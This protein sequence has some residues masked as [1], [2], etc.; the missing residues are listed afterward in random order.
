[1]WNSGSWDEP[2]GDAQV[3]PYDKT[4]K[5]D[6]SGFISTNNYGDN[7]AANKNAINN[8]VIICMTAF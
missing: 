4:N 7:N 5:N 2:A 1:M 8:I 3:W 6:N